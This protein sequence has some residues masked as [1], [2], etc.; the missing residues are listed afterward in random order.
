MLQSGRVVFGAMETVVFGKPAAETVAEEARR[1][2]V[3]RVFMMVSGTLNR[4]TDEIAKVGGEPEL[5][6]SFPF[7]WGSGLRSA[8]A[9][10]TVAV[11]RMGKLPLS[12]VVAVPLT[13]GP[14]AA[15]GQ[16]VIPIHRGRK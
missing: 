13:T 3:E 5:A 2:D 6:P 15:V 10:V 7:P 11:R 4:A 8:D 9:I 12:A 16:R 1:R 14:V